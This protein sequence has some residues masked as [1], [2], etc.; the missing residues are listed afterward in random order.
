MLLQCFIAMFPRADISTLLQCCSNIAETFRNFHA[1]LQ[2]FN[3]RFLQRFCNLSVLYGLSYFFVKSTLKASDL[4]IIITEAVRKI[5]SIGLK[6]VG[7]TR[8]G[9]NPNKQV[10]TNTEEQ[11]TYL[12]ETI[13]FLQRVKV[14]RK[15]AKDITNAIKSIRYINKYDYRNMP[16]MLVYM[17]ILKRMTIQTTKCL[18]VYTYQVQYLLIISEN[19][20]LNSSKILIL[21]L[22]QMLCK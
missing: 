3:V 8:H 16:I 9:S 18:G 10:Y 2:S 5:K 21:L 22:K 4:M 12:N 14:I 13:Q 11:V 17:H 20:I 7:L 6:V 19:Y 1:I 15:D